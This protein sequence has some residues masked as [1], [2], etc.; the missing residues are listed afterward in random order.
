MC[1]EHVE[2]KQR[3]LAANDEVAGR[4][5]H[6]FQHSGTLMINLI[7]SPGSGKTSLLEATVESLRDSYR[8]AALEGDVATQLDAA[9]LRKLGVPARQILTGE[10][11]HLDARQVFREVERLEE[12]PPEILFVEN[13]GNLVCP[14]TYDLGEDFKV[15]LLS[16][17]EG[18]DK[19]FKY[20]AIFSRAAV[21]V[22]T[23]VDLLPQTSFDLQRVQG[24]VAVL[25]PDA[26][27]IVT[28]AKNGEGIDTWCRYLV[29]HLTEKKLRAEAIDH[30]H[31]RAES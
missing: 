19:P 26:K 1:T 6:R 14:A 10:A 22:I 24:Q 27:F 23:K 29:E 5:N 4:L 8:L 17:V 13:V 16:V 25:N 2:V 18:D 31:A 3:V 30:A 15:A 12:P 11:C 9:R 28:S 20:P 21:T 7:S